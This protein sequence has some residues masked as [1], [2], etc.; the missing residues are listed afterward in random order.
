MDSGRQEVVPGSGNA[1]LDTWPVPLDD[2]Q[3]KYFGTFLDAKF[4]RE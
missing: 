4:L 3:D 1:F 2:V